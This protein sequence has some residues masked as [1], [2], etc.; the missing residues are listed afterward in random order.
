MHSRVF[1]AVVASSTLAFPLSAQTGRRP[2]ASVVVGPPVQI[3]RAFSNQPHYE[4]LSAGDPDHPGRL[5][6]CSTIH[7]VDRARWMIFQY[8]YVSFDSGRT[9][10]ATL[11]SEVD[12]S[13]QDPAA[14]YGR[15]DTVY[16]A[17]LVGWDS[18]KPEETDPDKNDDYLRDRT[19]IWRSIDGGRTWAEIGRFESIDREFLNVDRTNGKFGGRVYNVAQGSVRGISGASGP[20]SLQVMRSL[21]GGVTWLGPVQ[22]AYP[23]GSII[24]G[25]GTGTVLSDG[26][27]IANFGIAKAGRGQSLESEPNLGPNA[28]LHIARSVTGGETFTTHKIADIRLDRSRTEGGILNQLTSD[29]GSAAF[30]D[31]VYAVFPA[32]VDDRVQVQVSFSSDKGKTWSRPVTVND[33]R[34]PAPTPGAK[35]PDHILPSIGVN[36]DGV[37]LATWYDRREARNNLDW[38]LR[39]AYSLDGGESFS[40][41]FVITDVVNS[42]TAS[43]PWHLTGSGMQNKTASTVSVNVGL[44][45]FFT[46]GGHTTGMAVDAD[47]TFHPTWH[48]NNKEGVMQFW[49]AS[50]KVNGVGKKN[51]SDEFASME[52]ISKNV[53]LQ[54]SDPQI[55]RGSGKITLM[56]RLKNMTNDTVEGPVKVRV[57]S[58]SSALGV[59]EITNADNG[60]DGG[61]AVWDFSS[62]V[63]GPIGPMQLSGGKTLSFKV[64]DLRPLMGGRGY[65]GGLI[66][67]D[68]RVF[69]KLRKAKPPTEEKK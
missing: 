69:G 58:L 49:T 21:D 59:A 16:V 18:N 1:R 6:A 14:I 3:S 2:E 47:G 20:S 44:D 30:K 19:V 22:L 67:M 65:T 29:P 46:S 11:K 8:C 41:S 63:T 66:N 38:R 24:F 5:I 35:G 34:S 62:V 4:S 51:G 23:T 31:R 36:K 26:T 39:G 33:D 60:K 52:D 28:E 43:T 7:P 61:G 42:Y 32:V 25:V 50:I 12:W 27:Y 64:S 13:N 40:E 54:I 57:I 9:W 55:D 45:V 10:E 53:V 48:S 56:A 68:T 15:G 37:V 17:S